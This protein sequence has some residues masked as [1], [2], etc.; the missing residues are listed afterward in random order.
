MSCC[1]VKLDSTRKYFVLFYSASLPPPNTSH[2][3]GT[4]DT[5]ED[6][7]KLSLAP[8]SP[9]PSLSEP[10]DAV[11]QVTD[12]AATVAADIP[13]PE[14]A[15]TAEQNS[16]NLESQIKPQSI[17]SQNSAANE[18]TEPEG[19]VNIDSGITTADV[20]QS[21]VDCTGVK[22]SSAD[23]GSNHDESVQSD[24]CQVNN[25]MTADSGVEESEQSSIEL[26]R[27]RSDLVGCSPVEVCF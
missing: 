11:H 12:N 4:N 27:E 5:V 7:D 14:T 15:S 23:G 8:S 1:E 13:H 9:N 19:A 18:K 3:Q 6:V 17:E 25:Q 2:P 26:S 22:E 16:S 24:A 10:A 20:V 21:A